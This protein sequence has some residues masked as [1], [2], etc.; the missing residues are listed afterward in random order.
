MELDFQS[1]FCSRKVVFNTAIN[2]ADTP[3]APLS[4]QSEWKQP[5]MH[6]IEAGTRYPIFENH[7]SRNLSRTMTVLSRRLDIIA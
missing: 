6:N 5:Y 2:G 1:R 7:M 3:P 4:V